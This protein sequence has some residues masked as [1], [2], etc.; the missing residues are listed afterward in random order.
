MEIQFD[1]FDFTVTECVIAHKFEYQ[2][3]YIHTGYKNGR[4]VS[5]IVF[6][7][8]GEAKY[9]LKNKKNSVPRYCANKLCMGINL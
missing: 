4:S 8:G 1:D 2:S 9:T 5:G 6:C 3:G 7:T